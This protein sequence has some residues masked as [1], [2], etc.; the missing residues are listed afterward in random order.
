MKKKFHSSTASK[1]WEQDKQQLKK[2]LIF[3]DL[4]KVGSSY[5]VKLSE[6]NRTK[7]IYILIVI[8]EIIQ[9]T[10]YYIYSIVATVYTVL[11]LKTV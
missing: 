9:R 2:S 5:S 11:Y 8:L 6:Y 1:G 7:L 4:F 3:R 10:T